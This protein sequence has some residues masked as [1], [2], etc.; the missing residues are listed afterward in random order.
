MLPFFI[1][2]C[3]KSSAAGAPR[4]PFTVSHPS[5]RFS[6]PGR[7]LGVSECAG[8]SRRTRARLVQLPPPQADRMLP[9][10]RTHAQSAG[11]ARI[12]CSRFA[13]FRVACSMGALGGGAT[14]TH[15]QGPVLTLT[16]P[17]NAGPERGKRR[18]LPVSRAD[19]SSGR[20]NHKRRCNQPPRMT[21]IGS[22][23]AS[24]CGFYHG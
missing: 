24:G 22:V 16:P 1:S 15:G 19:A 6:P 7:G 12:R 5:L 3:A 14:H 21:T 4:P 9:P 20:R 18:R 17:R 10:R 23:S 2:R 13:S 8:E 11:R